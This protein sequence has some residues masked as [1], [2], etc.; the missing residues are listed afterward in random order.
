MRRYLLDTGP[1]ADF[2]NRRHSV[3]ARAKL[4]TRN[5][6]R[7]GICTPVLG[8]L[9]AGVCGSATRQRNEQRLIRRL[10]DL[11]VW[12]YD[13]M[14][15]RRFGEFSPNFAVWAPHAADRRADCSHRADTGELH[16]RQRGQRSRSNSW[17]DGRKFVSPASLKLRHAQSWHAA[18]HVVRGTRSG[19]RPAKCTGDRQHLWTPVGVTRE[20]IMRPRPAAATLSAKRPPQSP[21]A[22]SWP[23]ER[24]ARPQRLPTRPTR[25]PR[26]SRPP[27]H[28]GA[29]ART[30][31][32]PR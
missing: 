25:H 2:V 13:E 6:G 14:A 30:R 17:I 10:N 29:S 31:R 4:A 3:Y 15:A 32:G 12:P 21:C 9:W 7:V 5:G 11:I 22:A 23:V 18:L 16:R 8:E 1:A 24:P 20:T 27:R 26:L 28:T 19:G